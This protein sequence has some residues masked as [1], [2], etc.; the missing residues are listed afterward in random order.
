MRPESPSIL[1]AHGLARSAQNYAQAV[2]T[3]GYNPFSGGLQ[4]KHDNVRVTWEDPARRRLLR[5]PLLELRKRLGDRRLRV[6]DL[7]CGAGQGY[8]LLTRIE[9]DPRSLALQHNWVLPESAL[10]YTGV[11]LSAEMVAK[12]RETFAHHD[13]VRFFEGDLNEGLGKLRRERAFDLYYSS[14]GSFS[15]LSATGLKH[16]VCE[17]SKHAKAGSLVVLDLNARYSIEWPAYWSART[18]AEKVRDYTMNYLYLGNRAAMET[19]EHFPLRFWTGAELDRLVREA[20]RKAGRR[21]SILEKMDCSILVGRHVDTAEY[22]PGL[23]PWRRM[24]NSLHQ[25]YARTDLGRLT[26]PEEVAGR[27]PAVSPFLRELIFCWN[28]LIEFT[29]RRMERPVNLLDD[30]RW[31]H[32]PPALQF[33]IMGMDRIIAD[34]Q[35]MHYGDPRANYI[36]PQLGYMLRSLE[37]GLQRGLGCGHAIIV[38]LQVA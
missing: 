15:H 5:Q 26:V 31:S 16:L 10:E 29:R 1:N 32:Y 27:N 14:Y 23:K 25:D 22:N 24:V 36:E 7:G 33:A 20:G 21:L 2:A 9:K 28:S 19:A 8:E 17:I 37:Y 6:L 18:E 38:V 11:D 35:W 13:R 34:A 30:A 12:G 4:G 3:G